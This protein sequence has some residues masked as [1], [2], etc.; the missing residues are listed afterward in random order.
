LFAST[1]FAQDRNSE[2]RRH[3]D[4]GNALFA[5]GKYADALREFQAGYAIVRNPKFLLNMGQTYR[6]LGRLDEARRHLLTYMD[7]LAPQDPRRAQAAHIVAEIDLELHAPPPDPPPDIKTPDSDPVPLRPWRTT[8]LVLTLA[9][10]VALA[11]GGTLVG[12]AID[13][14]H[15]LS[16]PPAG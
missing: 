9:G 4:A 2:A 16:D 14:N 8:G 6:K 5:A 15:T 7:T 1:A 13:D 10:G 3:F 12:I 11:F